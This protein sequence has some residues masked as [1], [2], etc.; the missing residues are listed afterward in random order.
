MKLGSL[1]RFLCGVWAA[2]S[3]ASCAHAGS[4]TS[5][6]VTDIFAVLG[7][8]IR[9]G[10]DA[11]HVVLPPARRYQH[12]ATVGAIDE[13]AAVLGLSISPQ[14]SSQQSC[15]WAP[16]DSTSIGM[17]ITVT[18]FDVV[19]DSAKVSVL[20]ECVQRARGRVMLFQSEPTWFLKRRSG[21][22][23]VIGGT[24]R[25]TDR[26]PSIREAVA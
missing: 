9:K 25:V 7:D 24:M 18:E 16:V 3:A 1:G 10:G 2:A 21:R 23:I 4:V 6:T 17:D 5:S 15:Q 19:S 8:S 26:R 13:L 12:P 11:T 20:R 14:R 22:W